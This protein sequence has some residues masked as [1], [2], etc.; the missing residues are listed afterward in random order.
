MEQFDALRK[1]RDS[2]ARASAAAAKQEITFDFEGVSKVFKTASHV[3]EFRRTVEGEGI[4][5]TRL[6]LNRQAPLARQILA[7]AERCDRVR[8]DGRATLEAKWIHRRDREP[9]PFRE[10]R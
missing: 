7:E 6:P 3:T 9:R 2:A 8:K 10:A 4:G 1:T 5:L